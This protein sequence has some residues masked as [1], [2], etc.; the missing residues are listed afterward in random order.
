MREDRQVIDVDAKIAESTTEEERIEWEKNREALKR[1]DFCA[2]W[3]VW[4]YKHGCGHYEVLQTATHGRPIPEVR[5]EMRRIALGQRSC[6]ECFSRSV[7]PELWK[8]DPVKTK[9]PV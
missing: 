2:G 9:Y 8:N 6:S 7:N 1:I 3:D 5:A 4:I